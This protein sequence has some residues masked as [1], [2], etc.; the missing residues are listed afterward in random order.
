MKKRMAQE[1]F[2]LR[3]EHLQNGTPSFTIEIDGW[4][5]GGV[6]AIGKSPSMGAILRSRRARLDQ[7]EF[8]G[9]II[10]P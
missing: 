8:E 7:R 2:G 10:T 3:I 9:C 5:K 6:A 4:S 1:R